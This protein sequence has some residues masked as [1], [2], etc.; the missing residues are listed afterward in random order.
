MPTTSLK[1]F[2]PREGLS[3]F[4]NEIWRDTVGYVYLPTLDR[5]SDEWRKVFYEWPL[6]REHIVSHVLSATAQGLDV[7]YAPALF[8]THKRPTKDNV[9]GSHVLWCEFDGSAPENWEA[10]PAEPDGEAGEAGRE[11][12]SPVPVVPTPSLRVQTSKDG[13]EHVYWKLD[14]F[15]NDPNWLEEKNRSI[16]YSF[17]SD[18]SGWDS[19]QILRPPFTT[20]QKPDRDE[21]SRTV[22]VISD[23]KASY[24]LDRFKHLKAPPQLVTEAI[25]SQME[26]LP[27]VESVIAKYPW[28]ED[29]FKMFMDPQIPEGNRSDALMRLGYFCIETGMTDIEAYAILFNADQRWGKY[30]GRN[31]QK[32]RLADIIDRARQ[33]HPNPLSELTFRGLLAESSEVRKGLPLVYGFQDFLKSEIEVEW[34]I[35]NL[36][37][38]GGY[39]MVA[40]APGVGKT[41]FSIQLAM[42]CALGLPF[43]GWN[44]PKPLKTVIF[45][46]EMGHVSLK[47]FMEKIAHAYT[48]EQVAILQ[49]NFFVIPIGESIPLERKEGLAFVESILD[50]I[51]PDGIVWDSMAKLSSG[52]F[53][54]KNAI[55]LNDRFAHIRNKYNAFLWFI[56]HNRKASADNKKPTSLEDVYGNV[57]LTADMTSVLILWKDQHRNG[58]EVIPVKTRLAPDRYPFFAERTEHLTFFESKEPETTFDGLTKD[59]NDNNGDRPSNSSSGGLFGFG[60]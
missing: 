9:L 41:Q 49:E 11:A 31:D 2:S 39:G 25:I 4:F 57:F 13:H 29:H 18:T 51:Q 55:A 1:D 47:M 8:K 34:A 12:H 3:D 26:D 6:H 32:R 16:T 53:S 46:L 44:I 60:G 58:V 28:D 36:L 30:K 19:V 50:D 40:S 42:H 27:T 7:Y 54:D 15:I 22:S 14:E 59:K 21:N 43:L 20:N 10:D 48:P 35:E 45:S 56:H 17:R 24:P 37:E 38:M 23:T 52:D 33:K 5:K